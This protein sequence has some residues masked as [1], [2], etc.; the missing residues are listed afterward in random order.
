MPP[1]FEQ[2]IGQ[3]EPDSPSALHDVQEALQAHAA[4][5]ESEDCSGTALLVGAELLR[6]HEDMH[7]HPT[8]KLLG[9]FVLDD[10]GTSNHH[11]LL[12]AAPLAGAVLY[13]NHDG[14]TRVVFGSVDEFLEATRQAQARGCD[15]EDLHPRISPSATDQ[16]GLT[17]LIRRLLESPED[18]DLAVQL[19]PS[20]DLLDLDLLR[21]LATHENF[22][23]SEAVAVEIE[24]RPDEKLREIAVLCAEHKHPQ[25]AKAGKRAL[26]V[27][28]R[29]RFEHAGPSQS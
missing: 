2:P 26:T 4:R 22:F 15:V 18:E 20:L 24:K 17:A 14:D 12:T 9:G 23:I 27:E 21:E 28:E 3:L 16:E 1:L 7:S 10:P 29:R 13:L 25:A 6:W 19:I 8:L 11:V 5:I